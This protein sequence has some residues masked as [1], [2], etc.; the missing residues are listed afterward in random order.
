MNLRNDFSNLSQKYTEWNPEKSTGE[1]APPKKVPRENF[2]VEN[3]PFELCS[4]EN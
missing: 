4:P 3:Y 2:P 1:K